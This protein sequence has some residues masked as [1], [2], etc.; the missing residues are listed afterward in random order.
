MKVRAYKELEKVCPYFT[1]KVWEALFKLADTEISLPDTISIDKNKVTAV[2]NGYV[3]GS[4]GW[5]TYD[6]VQDKTYYTI[7]SRV[8]KPLL[9]SYG[10]IPENSKIFFGKYY[11][12]KN[13]KRYFIK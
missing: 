7:P 4:Q 12:Y 5:A 11:S 9:I 3:V 10:F 8:W 1:K 6:D 2:Y 13:S